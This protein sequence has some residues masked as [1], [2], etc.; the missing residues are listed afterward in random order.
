MVFG[1][2]WR[3]CLRRALAFVS[4]YLD[5]QS[6]LTNE[7]GL[8]VADLGV[9]LSV[10]VSLDNMDVIRSSRLISS[11]TCATTAT[12]SA[13]AIHQNEFIAPLA[14]LQSP[15]SIETEPGMYADTFFYTHNRS[16]RGFNFQIIYWDLSTCVKSGFTC[17]FTFVCAFECD[18]L[19]AICIIIVIVKRCCPLRL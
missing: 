4:D 14:T 6:I 17:Q 10:R 12:K 18:G 13:L 7:A 2:V 16:A 5:V 11:G 3:I 15:G 1:H 8:V 19:M 9:V